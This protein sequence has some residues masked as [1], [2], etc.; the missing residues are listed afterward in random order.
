MDRHLCSTRPQAALLAPTV[1]RAYSTSV[2]S[3]AAQWPFLRLPE[4]LEGRSSYGP[5]RRGISPFAVALSA[6]LHRCLKS[7][8]SGSIERYFQRA[9]NRY[10]GRLR[11]LVRETL[12][13]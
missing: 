9:E 5:I 3:Y 7:G 1:K 6:S 11:Q 2:P 4:G 10:K 8:I 12:V 13:A